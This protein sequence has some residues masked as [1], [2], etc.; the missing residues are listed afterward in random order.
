MKHRLPTTVAATFKPRSVKDEVALLRS[1]TRNFSA[2]RLY[3]RPLIDQVLA[4][5]NLGKDMQT[6]LSANLDRD[7]SIAAKRF[8]SA[9]QRKRY[10][11]STYFTWYIKTRLEQAGN[12][13]K[14]A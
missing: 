5:S 4:R 11:F 13:D 9:R 3:L 10:R 8:L 12:L 2:T 1:D 6:N 7:V 14:V